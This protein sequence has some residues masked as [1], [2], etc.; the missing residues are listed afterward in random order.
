M[1]TTT[2][3]N[4]YYYYKVS[5]CTI[6]YIVNIKYNKMLVLVL[7]LCVKFKMLIKETINQF[8]FENF[9]LFKCIQFRL[10]TLI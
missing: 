4:Y 5:V 6:A 10:K 8:V 3:K 9:H 2:A 7:N 1:H